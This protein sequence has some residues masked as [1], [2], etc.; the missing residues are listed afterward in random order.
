MIKY[1]DYCASTPIHPKVQDVFM[2]M[3]Q[4]IY[5]NPSSTHKMGKEA[6]SFVEKARQQTAELLNVE[7]EE[8]FFTSG[9][10]E[11]NNLALLGVIK[12]AKKKH[13]KI[14]IITTP[15][16]HSSIYSCCKFLESQEVEVSYIQVNKIG[17]VDIDCLMN[18]IRE[19]TILISIMHVNNETGVVQPIEEIGE[20]LK[21]LNKNIFFHVDG[22]QGFGKVHLKLDYIDMYTLSGH[23]I[24]A[25]K[26]IGILVIKEHVEVEPVI[27]GGDQEKSLRPGT[28]NV[29]SI[30]AVAEAIQI[31]K[32]NYQQSREKLKQFYITLFEKFSNIPSFVI[33]SA[34]YHNVSSHIFNFSVPGIPSAITLKV[35]EK[36]GIIASSQSACSSNGNISRVLMEITGDH[37][38]SSSSIRLSFHDGMNKSDI[39]YLIDTVL[40]LE[41]SFTSRKKILSLL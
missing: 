27:Y 17:I 35:L 24:G 15:I 3:T 11:S 14:H 8:V 22:A 29:P 25:P 36:N 23:K 5:A 41:D 39:D 26:G 10:T 9:A 38:L 12:A 28:L 34:E 31:G 1:F 40:S 32:Q 30:V 2:K 20:K 13:K 19:E 33:N 4:E 37:G 21:K 7:S 18:L 16:E 6:K